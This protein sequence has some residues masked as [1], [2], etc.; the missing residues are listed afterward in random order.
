MFLGL[1]RRACGAGMCCQDT[2]T[3]VPV[4]VLKDR[5]SSCEAV[6]LS[7]QTEDGNNTLKGICDKL[8]GL[9][10]VR[11]FSPFM[12]RRRL[13]ESAETWVNRTQRYDSGEDKKHDLFCWNHTENCSMGCMRSQA[14]VPPILREK[15]AVPHMS[16]KCTLQT[17]H[18]GPWMLGS[19]NV[20]W[21]GSCSENLRDKVPQDSFDSGEAILFMVKRGLVKQA[22]NQKSHLISRYL[23][24]ANNTTFHE[25]WVTKFP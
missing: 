11:V 1:F 22:N 16:V 4:L 7:W 5:M 17:L 20:P 19:W 18:Y 24:K 8:K 12:K 23:P 3:N 2:A 13:K 10:E 9:W 15:K 21:F 14:R 25:V 6:Q